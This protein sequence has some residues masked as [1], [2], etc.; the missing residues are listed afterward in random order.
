MKKLFAFITAAVA[1]SATLPAV[2]ATID[3]ST[4]TGAATLRNGDVLTGELTKE[5]RISIVD[6][7]VVTLSNAI[8]TNKANLGMLWAGIECNGDATIILSGSNAVGGLYKHP[9]IFV[10]ANK[11]LT[12]TGSGSLTA[13]GYG[14]G[15]G[16]GGGEGIDCGNIIIKGGVINAIGGEKAA[17]IG[18]AVQCS[19]G[20]ITI[21]GGTITAT[22]GNQA[23]GIGSGADSSCG[24]ITI[25]GG[26][27]VATCGRGCTN[28]IGAGSGGSCSGIAVADG[29]FEACGSSTRIVTAYGT[30][31]L[32]MCPAKDYENIA[33]C[34]GI[35]ITGALA[36][37]GKVS[38]ADGA[39]V[40]LRDVAINGEDSDSCKWA[41]I[42]CEGDAT[43]VLEGSNFVRGFYHSFPGIFVPTNKT[44]TIMGA[45][46]LTASS[47]GDGA[48]GIGSGLEKPCG[49]IVINGGT[50]VATGGRFAPGIGGTSSVCGTVAIGSGVTR[51][52]ATAGNGCDKPVAGGG[53]SDGVS[54]SDELFDRTEG[55]TRTIASGDIGRYTYDTTFADGSV[56]TGTLQGRLKMSIAA[57]ATVT[58]RDV[59]IS[60]VNDPDCKWAGLTCEGDATIV[61]AGNNYVSGF[62]GDYPGIYVPYGKTLTIRGSGSLVAVGGGYGAGIGGGF[63]IDC[64]NIDIK[65]GSIIAQGGQ[66]AAGIGTGKNGDCG[67]IF[68][69]AGITSIMSTCGADC[70][71]PIGCGPEGIGGGVSVESGLGDVSNGKTRCISSNLV[72]LS[73]LTGNR[74]V[75]DGFIVAGTLSGPYKIT[76]PDGA[77]VTLSGVTINGENDTDCKWAGITC[78]GDATIVIEGENTV[79]GF[80]EDY[81]G[82]YVPL[83]KTLTI[84][85]NGSLTASSNGKGA[86]IGGGN[87]ISCGS[88]VVESGTVIATGGDN[89]AG[90]GGGY[91]SACGDVDIGIGA[92]LVVAK[93]GT[94]CDNPIGAGNLG[95]EG[96][97]SVAD[98]LSYKE[99]DKTLTLKTG[100]L[101]YVT[102]DTV[103]SGTS[104][105]L[106]GEL[107]GNY[108]ITL[109]V[110]AL[111]TISNVVINGVNDPDC[112]WAGITCLGNNR[113]TIKGENTITGF[114]EDYPGISYVT[115][116][117]QNLVITGSGK[118]T[119]ASNGKGAGIG[120][121]RNEQ[122]GSLL[123]LGGNITAIGG[124][125]A[126]GIGS[127]SG[128]RCAGIYIDAATVTA[129]GGSGAAGI[130][131]GSGANCG[132]I[133]IESDISRVVATCGAG[134]VNPIGAGD[135]GG[136]DTVEVSPDMLSDETSGSTR[137]I[138]GGRI[139]HLD[140]IPRGMLIGNNLIVP[141]GR[142]LTGQLDED[143]K[144][145][146]WAGATVTLRDVYIERQDDDEHPWAGITCRGNA[147]IDL[148]GGNYVA[149]FGED[150]PGIYVPQGKT[151]TIRGDGSLEA[152][153]SEDGSGAGIG[154]GTN[155]G[156]GNIVIEGGTIMARGGYYAAGIG[157]TG[158]PCGVISITGGNIAAVG[159]EGAA[160]IGG[161]LGG[162]CRGISI[163]NGIE[164]V[165]ATAGYAL[166]NGDA[167]PNP[168][169]IGAGAGADAICRGVN[170][171]FGLNA[172]YGKDEEDRDTCTVT[173]KLIDLAQ[174][175]GSGTL[176]L[177]DGDIATGTLS[178]NYKV[179][180]EE[181]AT[182]MLRD[183][184]INEINIS[185]SGTPWA[186]ITCLGG[187]TI[188][189]DGE[190]MVRGC[191]DG[192]PGIF[193]PAGATLTIRGGDDLLFAG[194]CS[195]GAGIGGGEGT[196][197]KCG[198]IIIA[199]GWVMAVGGENASGMGSG[200]QSSCGDIT[201]SGCNVSTTGGSGGAGIGSG[202]SG[203]CGAITID[204]GTTGAE[205]GWYAAGIGTGQNG[206]CGAISITP[207]ITY[208]IAASGKDCVNPIGAGT[209][210]TCTGGVS[211]DK[212]LSD[213]TSESGNVR[214]ISPRALAGYS[215]WAAEKGLTGDDAAWDAKPA[216]WGGSWANAFVYTY[217]EGLADGSVVLMTISFDANGKPVITTAPVVEGHTDFTAA[218]VGS[219]TVDDWSSPVTLQ[220]NGN[221]WTLPA[222]KSANFFR[223]RLEE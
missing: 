187:A 197:R 9:G 139:I 41:G 156:C 39:T 82:I 193:V 124:G 2:A 191:Y 89:A 43:I 48:A 53:S 66:Y 201:I 165:A 130:G 132:T 168:S 57:G 7:A 11:T 182:V 19:C 91:G 216:M 204:G 38:I 199:G 149:A 145:S 46:V 125:G 152:A 71:K 222:G 29:M 23:V 223:V 95:T 56:I 70:S 93:C 76:I 178:A 58:L 16:I 13:C 146:I 31:D 3:L 101:A 162:M 119:A 196:D 6:G 62:Y 209:G 220:Q 174:L 150:H 188:D 203:Q 211:V 87:E 26:M 155:D 73:D 129:I 151:L 34:D 205:G 148:E 120:G 94:G 27:V 81:P 208:V 207:G 170:M 138:E 79:T 90:I 102:E 99:V 213:E 157:G 172:E 198:N 133:S 52:V 212:L 161:G 33:F 171:G 214:M 140:E 28:P 106:T 67:N 75:N 115:E 61:L 64:G 221:D 100:N 167:K 189:I 190:N 60:G 88:I 4:L 154:A 1:A 104:V 5:L 218:V 15:A 36:V 192:Y 142:I 166:E 37:N 135:H 164:C 177:K 32:S 108:K 68:A 144:I 122:C 112:K 44:L 219:E 184:C 55:A 50:V 80:H 159:G 40:T 186:G 200:Y 183:V 65:G 74:S 49:N 143:C 123:I 163:G 14:G 18:G 202:V 195:N 181:G 113:I 111:A 175:T 160:G 103:F 136:C 42:T 215:V 147:T 117:E 110:N 78:L 217:G 83:N 127:A 54:V 47:N 153:K 176:V 107:P 30:V 45:G 118:L 59:I 22:G 185:D 10:P 158:L 131:S 109:D 20:D 92:I 137:T 17:G 24:D 128:G 116:S 121:G 114:H 210:G 105:L 25:G 179:C 84:K 51:V 141:D 35:A 134:C 97:V 72:N 180:I 77:T 98:G 86:G 96:N 126:A 169:P 173:P 63:Y 12:I 206:R 69:R 194:G 8:V 21:S 85:G